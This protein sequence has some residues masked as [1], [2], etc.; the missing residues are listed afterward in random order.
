MRTETDQLLPPKLREIPLFDRLARNSSSGETQSPQLFQPLEFIDD[1]EPDGIN[2]LDKLS[3]MLESQEGSISITPLVAGNA[4]IN[5]LTAGFTEVPRKSEEILKLIAERTAKILG[6]GTESDIIQEIFTPLASDLARFLTHLD[7]VRP[8]ILD[9]ARWIYD[10]NTRTLTKYL[11]QEAHILL[12]RSRFLGLIPFT[13]LEAIENTN[14]LSLGASVAASSLDLLAAMGAGERGAV[15][16]IDFG[17]M[18]PSNQRRMPRGDFRDNGMPKITALMQ[19]LYGRNPHG[20]YYGL[21]AK[22]GPQNGENEISFDRLCGNDP[23]VIFEVI[24]RSD[25]KTIFRRWLTQEY[26]N[27]LLLMTADVGNYPFVSVEL[28]SAGKHF[29]QKNIYEKPSEVERLSQIPSS[30]IEFLRSIYLM[31]QEA[32][33]PEHQ[34]QF[35]MVALKLIPFWSQTPIAARETSAMA[36]KIAIKHFQNEQSQNQL[37][38]LKNTPNNLYPLY[39]TEQ[40]KL[41]IN[42]C[43]RVLNV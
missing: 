25:L 32:F 18:A 10:P 20:H 21:H 27:P 12:G 2:R 4:E 13:T 35:L 40:E 38:T 15:T 39:T 16:F 6:G 8:T 3:T 1:H 7:I 26:P 37:V 22:A 29:N 23:D 14:F 9:D 41:I 24:D 30:P 19:Q 28:P 33:P 17:E 36:A 31:V 43:Q 11:G 42:L 34:A 5:E